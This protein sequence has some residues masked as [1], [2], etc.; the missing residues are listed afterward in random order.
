MYY[1]ISD[2]T[3][4]RTDRTTE[5]EIIGK[6]K[7]NISNVW[8]VLKWEPSKRKWARAPLRPFIGSRPVQATTQLVLETRRSSYRASSCIRLPSYSFVLSHASTHGSWHPRRGS[9][10]PC[11]Q[12]IMSGH[13]QT[14]QE[15]H[16]L[17]HGSS[18]QP[19]CT[20]AS[21]RRPCSSFPDRKWWSNWRLPR[22][23][24][25]GWEKRREHGSHHRRVASKDAW[26][27]SD[28]RALWCHPYRQMRKGT[29]RAR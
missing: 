5:P 4:I 14:M 29:R 21:I 18:C 2:V 19:P 27:R 12:Q 17:A 25:T 3:F 24:S 16:T 23:A 9:C 22:T 26:T 7:E 10:Y 1:F 15:R 13:Q 8:A 6:E 11:N 28:P 20:L